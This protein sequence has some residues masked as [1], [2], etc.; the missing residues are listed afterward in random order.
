MKILFGFGF[1]LA[2]QSLSGFITVLSLP[3]RLDKGN[4]VG[5]LLSIFSRRLRYS[6]LFYKTYEFQGL[7]F[8][9]SLYQCIAISVKKGLPP[10]FSNESTPTTRPRTKYRQDR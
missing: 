7:R 1:F 6:E 2:F 9:L 8:Y 4:G 5:I 3:F 10:E